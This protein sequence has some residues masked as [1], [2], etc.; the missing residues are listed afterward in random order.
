MLHLYFYSIIFL[1]LAIT[2]ESGF[3]MGIIKPQVFAVNLLH[4]AVSVLRMAAFIYD[5]L[6][7]ITAGSC[8]CR[9]TARCM[10]PKSAGYPKAVL[11]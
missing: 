8:D 11:R 3:V 5:T 4:H 1:P 9:R 6:V 7:V 2:K 10:Y